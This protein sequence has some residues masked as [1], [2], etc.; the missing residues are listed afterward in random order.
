MMTANLPD[1]LRGFER[2]YS[3]LAD[4]AADYLFFAA[5]W[6]ASG[7]WFDIGLKF[8][9]LVVVLAA[10]HFA[11]GGQ[12]AM[13]DKKPIGPTVMWVIVLVVAGLVVMSVMTKS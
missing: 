12:T 5:T 9:A 11:L 10:L 3:R 4:R 1:I 8:G 2:S 6:F 7:S 13:G